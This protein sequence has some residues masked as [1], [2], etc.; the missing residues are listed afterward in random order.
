VSVEARHSELLLAMED[1]KQKLQSTLAEPMTKTKEVETVSRQLDHA[2]A[3]AEE[4]H[5]IQALNDK[6][7]TCSLSK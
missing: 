1:K 3:E 2:Q 6:R 4:H 5:R 7:L